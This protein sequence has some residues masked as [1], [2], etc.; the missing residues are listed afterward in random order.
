MRYCA[1][2]CVTSYSSNLAPE[3]AD[4]RKIITHY[5]SQLC[6]ASNPSVLCSQ[7][8]VSPIGGL[9]DLPR[10]LRSPHDLPIPIGRISKPTETP[11]LDERPSPPES[12][13]A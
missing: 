8:S 13:R 12:D 2:S 4:K 6:D 3:D 5:R 10:A 11:E 7:P 9:E 1:Q